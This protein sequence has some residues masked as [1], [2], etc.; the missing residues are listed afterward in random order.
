MGMLGFQIWSPYSG[1]MVRIVESD[2]ISCKSSEHD[3]RFPFGRPASA[4]AWALEGLALLQQ[5]SR[6]LLF[7]ECARLFRS[8]TWPSGSERQPQQ[9]AKQWLKILETTQLCASTKAPSVY[10]LGY[11]WH[12]TALPFLLRRSDPLRSCR[13]LIKNTLCK[14]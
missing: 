11:Q 12:G 14:V 13:S 9:Y 8:V 3:P 7:Q 5:L 6:T 10:G 4:S 2:E 1:P